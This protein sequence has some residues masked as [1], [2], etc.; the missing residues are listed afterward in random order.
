[1]MTKFLLNVILTWISHCEPVPRIIRNDGINDNDNVKKNISEK[2]N[3][4]R[5]SRLI[6]LGFI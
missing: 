4:L 2:K 1:M 6:K 5:C 3:S